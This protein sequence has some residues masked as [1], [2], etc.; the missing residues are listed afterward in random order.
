MT[1]HVAGGVDA[2]NSYAYA[3]PTQSDMDFFERNSQT[4]YETMGQ[5]GH[6]FFDGIRDRMQTIDF[7]KLR[8][9]T[10]AITRR[11]SSFWDSDTIKPLTTLS[12]IQFPPNQM[13]RWQMA[14]PVARKLYHGKLCAGYDDKYVDLQPGVIG[15]DH[16]DFQMVMDGMEQYDSEGELYF[17]SY[18]ETFSEEENSVNYLSMSERVD[19]IESWNVTTRLFSEM[20]DDPTS[21]YSGML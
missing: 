12:D 6:Q 4:F 10:H 17:V 20:R 19:I 11:V 14:N 16:H 3:Q 9:Y 18:D 8:E 1:F 5:Y 15:D 21:Q 2:F 13:I 7:T